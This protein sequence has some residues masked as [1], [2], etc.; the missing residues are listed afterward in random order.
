MSEK[1]PGSPLTGPPAK[2]AA[3]SADITLCIYD[4]NEDMQTIRIP[5]PADAELQ[6]VFDAFFNGI[7]TN[8]SIEL[9]GDEDEGLND[10]NFVISALTKGGRLGEE[11]EFSGKQT[12]ELFDHIHTSNTEFHDPSYRGGF[13][14]CWSILSE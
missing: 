4:E 10:P 2:R 11:Y 5:R 1:R 8:G 6:A 9:E 13:Y 3:V 14:I 12:R 7:R